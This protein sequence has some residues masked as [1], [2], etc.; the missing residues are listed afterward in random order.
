[1]DFISPVEV[2]FVVQ[3]LRKLKIKDLGSEQWLNQHVAVIKLN[4]QC[5][6]EA[7]SEGREELTKDLINQHGKA[8]LLVHDL[9]CVFVWRKNILPKLEKKDSIFVYSIG[10]H[11]LILVNLLEL[12]LYNGCEALEDCALDLVDYCVQSLTQVIGLVHSGFLEEEEEKEEI[13]DEITEFKLGIHCISL[14]YYLIDKIDSLPLSV[15]SRLIRFHDTPCLLSE[16][17]HCR[18]WQRRTKKGFEKYIEGKWTIISGDEYQKICKIEAQAWFAFRQLLFNNTLM[19]SYDWNDFRCREISKCVG[20][21][22]DVLLDQL[23][24][25]LQ[26]KQF[27]AT[28][29]IQ[30]PTYAGGPSKQTST[31]L[32]LEEVPELQNRFLGEIKSFGEKNLIQFQLELFSENTTGVARKLS[33]AYNVERIMELEGGAAVAAQQPS[34]S[35]LHKCGQC[36]GAAEK[37]CSKCELVFYCSRD[38]QVQHW[39]T[40]KS[41]CNSM[42]KQAYLINKRV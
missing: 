42:S 10:Y 24:P 2:D 16:V 17:L 41:F 28:M 9:F 36:Q 13:R 35:N 8:K 14:I 21:I 12:I 1:M 6:L 33:E 15:A 25:L 37:K 4:Q 7:K 34:S 40:H 26:L 11:E 18:P 30:K 3:S 20:L 38:C 32:L 5:V 22:N 27:L 39:S 31:S 23:T 19:R 29:S